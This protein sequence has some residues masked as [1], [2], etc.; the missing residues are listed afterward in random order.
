MAR[1]QKRRDPGTIKDAITRVLGA[2]GADTAGR[3]IGKSGSWAYA[4][5]DPD[6]DALPTASQALCLDVAYSMETGDTEAPIIS[7]L[8]RLHAERVATIP[9]EAGDPIARLCDATAATASVVSQLRTAVASAGGL[10]PA[11]AHEIRQ[12][13]ED[14][15]RQL[16]RAAKDV[17]H[18]TAQPKVMEAAE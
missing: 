7:T 2:I 1:P 11:E 5:G 12:L 3:S 9:Y 18:L 15:A 10:P 13:L 16:Q 8:A 6:S 17:A 4:L 14:Q